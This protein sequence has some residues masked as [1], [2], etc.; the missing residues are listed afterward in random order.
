MRFWKWLESHLKLFLILVTSIL[1]IQPFIWTEVNL[2]GFRL[3]PS[4][5]LSYWIA[6]T[7]WLMALVYS[8]TSGQEVRK[9]LETG[10]KLEAG[11]QG[12]VSLAAV[13]LLFFLGILCWREVLFG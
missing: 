7:F 8:S 2:A 10:S 1:M 9:L 3:T 12:C 5:L 4:K 13:L 11:I 6:S